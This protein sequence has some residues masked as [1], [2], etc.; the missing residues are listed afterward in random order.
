M[1]K[2]KAITRGAGD[3]EG[4]S[5]EDI[6]SYVARVSNP[7]N[8]LNFNTAPKLIKYC[9]D[10]KH[11]SV[12][13]TSYMTVEVETSRAIAAQILRHGKG[14][15]FQEF[16]LSGDTLIS[17]LKSNKKV[18]IRIDDLYRLKNLTNIKI[19]VFDLNRNCFV[20][21]NIKEIMY[22]GENLLYE[23][24]AECGNVIKSTKNHRFLTK[25]GFKSLK[26]IKVGDVIA[27]NGTPKY[28]DFNI[29][30]EAKER[31]IEDGTGVNGIAKHFNISYHTVRK[32]LKKFK[33]SFSKREVS[34]YTTAWNKG[35]PTEQQPRY[36]KIISE[37]TRKKMSDS[38]RKGSASNLYKGGVERSFRQKVF[39]WQFKYKNYLLKKFN[40]QCASCK[41]SSNLE[42]DHVIPVCEDP[43]LAFSIKNLQILCKEC[44]K[45]KTSSEGM[46]IRWSKVSSI[47]ELKIDH[48]YDIEVEND[49]HNFIAN[50]FVVH[51]SQR[52][53]ASTENVLYEARRQDKKNRQNSID[54]LSS[55]VKNWFKSAQEEVWDLSFTLYNKALDLGIAKECARFL[56]P[57]STKTTIY[58]TGNVRSWIHYLMVRDTSKGAQAEHADIAMQCKEIF[59]K[60]FPNVASALDWI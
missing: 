57:L 25:E 1:A 42:I 35:L 8:Q 39:D 38:S 36:G 14:F 12:F 51:N 32:W 48:T 28:Q 34:S 19:R 22:S 59:I 41:G 56:L 37:Q 2:L 24:K 3:L 26:D 11:W 15:T 40:N 50:K 52:Y 6:I 45:I 60:E 33:I 53:S 13:E 7:K 18:R 5:A 43:D 47:N 30:K 46:T 23:V 49:N 44:H 29:L 10:E 58:I 20:Y 27:L 55:D 54:D 9:I 31:C 17:C 4:L 16:C 21:S